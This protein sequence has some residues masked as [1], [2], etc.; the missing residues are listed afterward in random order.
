MRLVITAD[1][2]RQKPTEGEADVEL[3][4]VNDEFISL[5]SSVDSVK[6][7]MLHLSLDG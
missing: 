3:T 2:V 1:I 7:E 5:V 4:D 6:S